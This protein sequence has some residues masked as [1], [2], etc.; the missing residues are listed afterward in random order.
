M[1][2]SI[3]RSLLIVFALHF[4]AHAHLPPAHSSTSNENVTGYL[5]NQIKTRCI[6]HLQWDTQETGTALLHVCTMLKEIEP[7]VQDN[8]I[9]AFLAR[10]FPTFIPTEWD[11]YDVCLRTTVEHAHETLS[12]YRYNSKNKGV[13]IMFETLHTILLKA[14]RD[15]LD[16]YIA[17]QQ[18]NTPQVSTEPL[19]PHVLRSFV[20]KERI[21]Q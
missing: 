17:A 8:F 4:T 20:N 1:L 9:D 13:L 2:Q 21:V 16:A 7:L 10:I 19:S 5:L 12:E 15:A 18:R 14:L 11:R 6:N 3:R